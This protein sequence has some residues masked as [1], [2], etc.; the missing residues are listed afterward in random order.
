MNR[1]IGKVPSWGVAGVKLVFK[2]DQEVYSAGG[3][4]N[5]LGCCWGV[6]GV[7]NCTN[8]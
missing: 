1:V 3:N 6:M 5:V 8:C 7:G 4:I 2:G